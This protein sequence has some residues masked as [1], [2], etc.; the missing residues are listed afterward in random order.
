MGSLV[1]RRWP[2]LLA[3]VWSLSVAAPA[4]AAADPPRPVALD[5]GWELADRA[6][7]PWRETAVPSVIDPKPTKDVFDGRIA[8]YRLTFEG[9]QTPEGHSWGLRF[10]QVRRRAEVFL[11]GRRI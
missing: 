6:E 1:R 7:G 10:E 8:W 5:R 2:L 11:N 9:P 3:T 4:V